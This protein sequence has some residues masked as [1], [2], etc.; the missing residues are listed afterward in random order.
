LLSILP[1]VI[2]IVAIVKVC[3]SR[4]SRLHH[5]NHSI[6]SS[7]PIIQSNQYLASHSQNVTINDAPPPYSIK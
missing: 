3:R 6:N 4:P 2:V 7:S 1:L 5:S